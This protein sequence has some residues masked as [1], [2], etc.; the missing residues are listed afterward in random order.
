MLS[1]GLLVAI[2]ALDSRLRFH[3]KAKHK[4]AALA[5]GHQAT[6][7]AT[8][9]GATRQQWRVSRAG[10]V[11]KPPHLL[12][13]LLQHR[14]G[15]L[16]CPHVLFVSLFLLLES[17]AQAADSGS[18][19]LSRQVKDGICQHLLHEEPL[20]KREGA[21]HKK[22]GFSAHAALRLPDLFTLDCLLCLDLLLLLGCHHG[23][24]ARDL[25]RGLQLIEALA[26]QHLQLCALG[27]NL[28]HV[29]SHVWVVLQVPAQ[30][31]GALP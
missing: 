28:C 15:F 5:S 21:L 13:L 23:H 4:W 31:L 9:T 1:L 17:D 2:S 18:R 26:K 16:L 19:F 6:G 11:D 3:L 30:L 12:Q 24:Q 27:C 29:L 25:P 7:D 14:H 22:G 8:A 20:S 10:L